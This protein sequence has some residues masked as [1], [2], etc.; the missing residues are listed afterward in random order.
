MSKI[1]A[2]ARRYHH[3]GKSLSDELDGGD[4]GQ[5]AAVASRSLSIAKSA[6]PPV[7][8]CEFAS[9]VFGGKLGEERFLPTVDQPKRP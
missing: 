7:G 2:L 3:E 6:T 1:C 9:K 8:N 5:R 4:G